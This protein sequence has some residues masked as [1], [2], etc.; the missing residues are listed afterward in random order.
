[1]FQWNATTF[2]LAKF[3][4]SIL[5]MEIIGFGAMIILAARTGGHTPEGPVGG[6]LIFIPPV[7]WAILALLFYRTESPS[8]QLTYTVLLALPLIQA[9]VGPIYET[10]QD[11]W[12]ERGRAGAD[13][14]SGAPLKLANAVY[15]HDVERVKRLMPAA[16][17]LNKPYG[18]KMTLFD[19]AM[20]NTDDSDAS[21]D[22]I[23]AMLTAGGN[24]NVPPG[25]PLTLAL[26]RSPR[27]AELLLDAGADPNALDDARRPVWWTVL[28]A[29]GD[30]D[31]TKLRLLL[32]RGADIKKRDREGGPIAWAAYQKGWRAL[33]LLMQHGAEWEDEQEF[34]EPVHRMLTR[35]LEYNRHAVP[36]ELRK[37]LAKYEEAAT[38]K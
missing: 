3:F 18:S 17:D 32:H 36:D 19:F 9:A 23:R 8:K 11:A 35:E 27:F 10:V 4:W 2:P 15:D 14:F 5:I 38:A 31:L 29:A 30:N 33:W 20:S 12:W 24:A 21:F 13:Y 1:M 25:R 22:I 28:S 37:A 26:Y 16:G 7:I 34:G 6:W